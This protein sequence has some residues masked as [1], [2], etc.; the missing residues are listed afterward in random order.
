MEKTSRPEVDKKQPEAVAPPSVKPD[1][2]FTPNAAAMHWCPMARV[3]LLAN[4]AQG[5]PVGGFPSANRAP[6][7]LVTNTGCISGFCAC[8]RWKELPGEDI[9]KPGIGYCGLAGS[10]HVS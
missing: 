9:S 7:G 8:W 6:T 2:Y 4:D 1:H 5:R 3:A 10:P